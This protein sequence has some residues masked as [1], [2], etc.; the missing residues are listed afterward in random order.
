MSASPRWSVV[1]TCEHGGHD[2]PPEYRALFRDHAALLRSHRG[3]DPGALGLARTL[4]ERIGATLVAATTTRLLVDLNRSPHNP[5]VLS[6]ITRALPPDQRAE[7]LARFHRPHWSAVSAAV[8]RA[9]AGG[10]RVLHLGVHSFTP[11][12]EG[13]SR[14]P[15]LAL[16]CDPARAPER[17]LAT[18]WAHGLR[19]ELPDRVVARNDPYRG[20]SDGL[21]TALRKRY[22]PRRYA[23]IEIEV[24]QK[25]IGRQGRFPS[26]VSSALLRTLDEALA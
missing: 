10:G 22:G 25:H 11:V 20:T 16:L 5:R 1:V 6:E 18:A 19:R 21:A 8:E 26:W 9:L 17:D 4:A 2:V 3:W 23:G 14:R 13:V 15:D 24:N 12:L 7:L